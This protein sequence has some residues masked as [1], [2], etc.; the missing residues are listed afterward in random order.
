[1][2]K[3]AIRLLCLLFLLSFM[4]LSGRAQ[5]YLVG[6]NTQTPTEYLDIDGTFRIRD[7]PA[8]GEKYYWGSVT[9]GATFDPYSVVIAD[10]NGVL[11]QSSGTPQ[12]TF[13][14]PPIWLPLTEIMAAPGELVGETFHI[15]LYAHYKKQFAFEDATS[16]AR[17]ST[18]QTLPYWPK[19]SLEFF[20][21]YY[22]KDVFD[23]VAISEQGVLTYKV[24]DD[25]NP[26]ERTFMNILFNV[27]R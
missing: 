26:T 20:I 13:Y 25:S 22:D 3:Q 18:S 19:E 12:F 8:K 21:T 11:G 14:M 9:K 6:V 5:S 2:D 4:T 7:L 10:K 23:N 16:S 15:D 1:M 27:K 17:V 24:K